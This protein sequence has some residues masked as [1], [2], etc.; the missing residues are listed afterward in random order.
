MLAMV[1]ERYGKNGNIGYG[2][3]T[4]DCCK[5]GTVAT[6][7]CHDHH[8]LFVA[9]HKPEDMLL[10]VQRLLQLQGGFLVV[11]EGEIL[12]ELALPV[13]GILSEGSVENIGRAVKEIRNAMG[14]LGYKHLNPIMSFGTL[15]LPVSPALKLTDKG[16]ID[17]KAGEIV[18]LFIE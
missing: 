15:G 11:N 3:L 16:L 6:T 2:F 9:G 5:K 17:V 13:C 7:Y 10:A 4:G 1:I 8:N 14:S 18:P 12:A